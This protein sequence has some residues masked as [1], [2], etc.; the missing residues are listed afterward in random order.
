MCSSRGVGRLMT[1]HSNFVVKTAQ[2]LPLT[3]Y[4]HNGQYDEYSPS[5]FLKAS[6]VNAPL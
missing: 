1:S 2:L 3:K 5:L 6:V 4:A